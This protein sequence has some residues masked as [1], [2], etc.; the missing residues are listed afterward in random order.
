MTRFLLTYIAVLFAP[1]FLFG[2]VI[3]LIVKFKKTH[4]F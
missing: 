2:L 4:L 3:V 1:G